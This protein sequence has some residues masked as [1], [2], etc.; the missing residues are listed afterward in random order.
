[1]GL[2]S[3]LNTAL[4]GLTYN[5]KQIDVTASNIANADTAGYST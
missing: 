4:F 3:A 1:M 5:Q 2:T